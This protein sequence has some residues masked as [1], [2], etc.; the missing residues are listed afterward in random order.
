MAK[1]M[2]LHK[3]AT[4]FPTMSK[5]DFN[6]L[7]TDI[8]SNGLSEPILLWDGQVVDG[9]HRLRACK[10]LG[11]KPAFTNWTVAESPAAYV[12]RTNLC[13]RNL[14]ASQRAL[15]AAK[16]ATLQRGT[17]QHASGDASTLSQKEA[18]LVFGCSRASVQRGKK[19][20]DSRNSVLIAAVNRG[21]FSLA[22]GA[23]V[24]ALPRAQQNQILK[25]GTN[26]RDHRSEAKRKLAIDRANA[27]NKNVKLPEGTT[28]AVILA[29]PPWNYGASKVS[30]TSVGPQMHYPTMST[31]EIAA[32]PIADLA[33]RNAVL[34]LWVPSSLLPDG[35]QVMEAWGFK[36]VTSAIWAKKRA[37]V[38]TG[39]FMP[40][41]EP[42]LVGRRGT[43]L[44]RAAKSCNSVVS[45][46]T[47]R[48]HSEKPAIF[49][50]VIE[51]MYPNVPRVELFAR[52]GRK[53]WDLWGNQAPKAP[54]N[55]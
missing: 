42:L 14:T 15:L 55:K 8:K 28:Y 41:H 35:L 7:K 50:Q 5:E 34:F 21:L 12:Y 6:I 10:E 16:Y 19:V 1:A 51:Q 23:E 9:K 2:K 33:Q 53:G 39:M 38:S 22:E 48:K 18:A 30:N 13:R 31:A 4:E 47:T 44:G 36:Y 3:L 29:D 54:K 27:L 11:I 26:I 46:P 37:V 45:I 40:M 17:N 24:A 52:A 20:H 25:S 49:H 32:M 43:G